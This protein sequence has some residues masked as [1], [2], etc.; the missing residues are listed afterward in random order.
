MSKV[1][2]DVDDEALADAAKV[3]GTTTKK[4][5]VNTALREATRRIQRARALDRL[6]EMADEGDFDAF[7]GGKDSYR[8]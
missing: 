3:F 5:T 1:L 4:D 6:G 2:V 7:L 8:P